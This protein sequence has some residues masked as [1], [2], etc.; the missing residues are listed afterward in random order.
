MYKYAIPE[1]VLGLI[2][3]SNAPYLLKT[4]FPWMKVA[5]NPVEAYKSAYLATH[6]KA[7]T[8][9][10]NLYDSVMFPRLLRRINELLNLPEIQARTLALEVLHKPVFVAQL[11]RVNVSPLL[12]SEITRLSNIANNVVSDTQS[13]FYAM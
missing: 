9:V 7:P 11:L 12:Y 4:H 3:D 10:Q 2:S 1:S 6:G 8:E 13:E 5:T